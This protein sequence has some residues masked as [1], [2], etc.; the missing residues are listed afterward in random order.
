MTKYGVYII[1][2]LRDG[3]YSDGDNLHE[4]L[5]L[6]CIPTKYEWVDTKEDLQLALENFER[7]K[8]RYL[9]ISCHADE[10]G[11]EINSD[12]ITNAEFER[13]TKG[14]LKNKRLFLSACR[15]ANRDLASRIVSNNKAY[16]LVGIPVNLYFDKSALFWPSFYHLVNEIDEKK[17]RRLQI[18]DVLKKLVNLFNIPVNYYSRINNSPDY[19]RRL[20]IRVGR[21]DNRRIKVK[22]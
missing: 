12:E 9:H 11:L 2:F 5:K 8:Y 22:I 1:E 14:K 15:G 17:M 13:M 20:K 21:T 4:I 19:M 18:I 6:S 3:D 7:S 16:S 10:T